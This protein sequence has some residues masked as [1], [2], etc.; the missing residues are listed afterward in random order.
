MIEAHGV[1]AG[2]DLIWVI[3]N[4]RYEGDVHAVSGSDL[5]AWCFANMQYPSNY[6]HVVQQQHIEAYARAHWQ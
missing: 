2:Q 5:K 1:W 4:V 3:R 6:I